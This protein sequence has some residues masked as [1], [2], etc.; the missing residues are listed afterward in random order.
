[1]KV[2]INARGYERLRGDVRSFGREGAVVAVLRPGVDLAERFIFFRYETLKG[3][4]AQVREVKRQYAALDAHAAEVAARAT[5]GTLRI[6][7]RVRVKGGMGTMT[8][9]GEYVAAD[10]RSR[11]WVVIDGT[12]KNTTRRYLATNVTKVAA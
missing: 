10:G 12:T 11:V 3:I 8:G 9:E 7:D 4:A 2:T 6:G 5:D 1:M